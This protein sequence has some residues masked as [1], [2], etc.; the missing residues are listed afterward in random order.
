MMDAVVAIVERLERKLDEYTARSDDW[1][2]KTSVRLSTLEKAMVAQRE[3]HDTHA[4]ELETIRAQLDFLRRRIAHLDDELL[5][6][7]RE[8]NQGDAAQRA[9]LESAM[10]IAAKRDE[11]LEALLVEVREKHEVL[12]NLASSIAKSDKWRRFAR[13]A[14]VGAFLGGALYGLLS[15]LAA[16]SPLAARILHAMG[17]GP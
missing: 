11:Q 15:S 2:S 9:A 10:A 1:H 3:N 5:R 4:Q 17:I 16:K 8:A 6:L 13:L 14:T 12:V 7:K